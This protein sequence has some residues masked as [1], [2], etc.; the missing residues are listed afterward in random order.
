MRIIIINAILEIQT[1]GG[2]W[3]HQEGATVGDHFEIAQNPENA[4]GQ[5]RDRPKSWKRAQQLD[6]NGTIR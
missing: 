5:S 4:H 1:V 3:V 6:Q 2:G